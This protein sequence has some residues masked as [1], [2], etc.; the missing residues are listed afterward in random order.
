MKKQYRNIV[1]KLTLDELIGQ[2]MCVSV[3]AKM[4]PQQFEEYCKERKPGGIFVMRRTGEEVK[5][6]L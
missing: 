4:T 6:F 2:L 5:A 3:S 1:Q